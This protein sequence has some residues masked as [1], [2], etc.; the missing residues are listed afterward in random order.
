M[1]ERPSRPILHLKAATASPVL[2]PPAAGWR[3]KPCGAVVDV[4]SGLA[5]ADE[6]R[7]PSCGALLGRA[8]QFRSDPPQLQRIRARR[9]GS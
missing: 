4:N 6:V 8:G 2:A 7:C 1:T 9:V 3:C 5:D